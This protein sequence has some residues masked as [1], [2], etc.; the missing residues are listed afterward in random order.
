MVQDKAQIV[1]WFGPPTATTKFEWKN[2]R[3]CTERWEW[4]HEA[5]S[6]DGK[7]AGKALIVDFDR[8]GKVCDRLFTQNV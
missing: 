6:Q 3:G 5:T 2:A 1:D 7:R 4:L 8:D